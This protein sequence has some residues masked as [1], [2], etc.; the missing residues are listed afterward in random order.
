MWIWIRGRFVVIGYSPD[1]DSVRFVPD[2]VA[3]VRRLQHADR[4]EVSD[5][6][7]SVQLRLDAI[8]APESHYQGQAQ[9]LALPAR[10]TLLAA[11]GFTGLRF[12][13]DENETVEA[14]TP[15]SVPGAIA[16]Q[17]VETNGRPVALVF[18]GDVATAHPD[19]AV[20]DPA[21]VVDASLNAEQT[22]NGRAYL[23]LY[24]STPVAVRERFVALA[25]EAGAGTS[26]PPAGSV[27]AA[28]RSGGFTLTTQSDIG[29]A[30]QLVLPKLFRRATDYLRAGTTGTF[31]AWLREQG[32]D[33]DPVELNGQRARL[34]DVVTQAGD[35]VALTA[36]PLDLIF[37]EG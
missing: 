30:G 6:D 11:A 4:L 23:T 14:S 2:Q 12:G 8:D 25:R 35:R 34:S 19:G 18:V 33:D 37:V 20:V 27:W 1:G 15:E 32:P 21:T 24:T 31:L 36:S 7:G 5:K 10:D 29:P 22:R 26:T 13:T 17:L 16:A 28:D 3:T 9:P